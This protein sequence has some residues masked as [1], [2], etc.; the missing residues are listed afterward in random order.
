MGPVKQKIILLTTG[1]TIEKSY[2]EYDGSLSNRES[3]IHQRILSKLRLP[4]CELEI[5]SVL[6]KD[7]LDLDDED[8]DFIAI[9][10]GRHLK[11]KAPIVV[12]HG[13]DTMAETAKLCSTKIKDLEVPVIFTGAMRPLGFVDTDALQNCV[14]ALMASKILPAGF[15]I[16]FHNQIFQVPN[17]QKNLKLRTFEEIQ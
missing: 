9:C 8:R 6:A 3:I 17:V 7:S 10:I 4:Y 15:Y 11:S 1:G 14:E 2:N 5:H 12:F 16:S 13:T